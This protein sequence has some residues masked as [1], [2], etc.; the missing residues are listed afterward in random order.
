M[1]YNV[2]TIWRKMLLI[3]RVSILGVKMLGLKSS[4]LTLNVE[5]F[6]TVVCFK[7]SKT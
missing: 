5:D 7:L 1:A 4:V 3:N 2:V 6:L